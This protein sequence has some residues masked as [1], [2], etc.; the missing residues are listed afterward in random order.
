[1]TE[2][3]LKRNIIKIKEC[4]SNNEINEKQYTYIM[5]ELNRNDVS[6]DYKYG[7]YTMF[8]L[9]FVK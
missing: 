9:Y 4:Y 3:R 2:Y 8:L 6:L 5:Y 1:M 7:M